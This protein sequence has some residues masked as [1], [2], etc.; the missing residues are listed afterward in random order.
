MRNTNKP[1]WG[2]SVKHLPLRLNSLKIV[3]K[4]KSVTEQ[5]RV[6]GGGRPREPWW[7]WDR[8]AAR[9]EGRVRLRCSHKSG[10]G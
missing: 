4:N 7:S 5:S 8:Q 10:Q 2:H 1:R 9:A 6:N 3:K